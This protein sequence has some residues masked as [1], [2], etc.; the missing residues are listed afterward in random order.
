VPAHERVI[1][2]ATRCLRQPAPAGGTGRGDAVSY[3]LEGGYDGPL[4]FER[5][6]VWYAKIPPGYPGC[7]RCSLAS[8]I[9]AAGGHGLIGEIGPMGAIGAVLSAGAVWIGAV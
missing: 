8:T 7:S 3:R 1:L 4:P 9:E 2:A 6:V 5:H